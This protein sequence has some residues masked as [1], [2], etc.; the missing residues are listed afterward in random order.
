MFLLLPFCLSTRLK[1]EEVK[2]TRNARKTKIVKGI[3]RQIEA[4]KT[5][6]ILKK[7]RQ[8]RTRRQNKRNESRRRS[9][10]DETET[11][12]E[13]EVNPTRKRSQEARKTRVDSQSTK[14]EKRGRH[15][16]ELGGNRSQARR[17]QSTR[18]VILERK[19]KNNSNSSGHEY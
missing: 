5:E 6:R 2:A 19:Q 10:K 14:D 4:R 17:R 16:K 8:C 3:E 15:P 9:I 1:L 7:W 13:V 12:A 18:Y 11:T